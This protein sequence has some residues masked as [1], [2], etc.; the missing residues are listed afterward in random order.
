MHHVRAAWCFHSTNNETD[1]VP[2]FDIE[3]KWFVNDESTPQ[4]LRLTIRETETNQLVAMLPEISFLAEE[5]IPVLRDK[6][7]LLALAPELAFVLE[8][9]LYAA[10]TRKEWKYRDGNLYRETREEAYNLLDRVKGL[11]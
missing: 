5:G 6:A 9:L 1:E 10:E 11:K 4:T 8:R 7:R 3:G 2:T